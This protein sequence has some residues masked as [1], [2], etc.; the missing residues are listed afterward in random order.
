ML[1]SKLQR[2]LKELI[3]ALQCWTYELFFV[4]SSDSHILR[5]NN[6]LNFFFGI[7]LLKFRYL[8]PQILKHT[9]L[10]G[11]WNPLLLAGVSDLVEEFSFHHTTRVIQTN[12]QLSFSLE[13][14]LLRK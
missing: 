5:E 3:E 2:L 10:L 7:F 9:F 1:R 14:L 13:D 6:E 4:F 8:H 11:N 12:H